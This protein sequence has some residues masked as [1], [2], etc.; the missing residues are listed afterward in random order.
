[1]KAITTKRLPPTNFKG[2]RISAFDSD[3]NRIVI[4]YYYGLNDEGNH[5]AAAEALINKM[6][7]GGRWI[8]GATKEGY[9]HVCESTRKISH[10]IQKEIERVGKRDHIALKIGSGDFST[11][12]LTISQVQL[13]EIGEILSRGDYA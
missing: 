5:K 12:Y 10:Y 8:C 13:R 4:N 11:N 7:W 3:G 9:V 6:N 1:M 2:A